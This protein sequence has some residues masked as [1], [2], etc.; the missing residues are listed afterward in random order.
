[1]SKARSNGIAIL[2]KGLKKLKTAPLLLEAMLQ[3]IHCWTDDTKYELVG[4][5]HPL[6]FDYQ[7]SQLLEHQSS[8]GWEFLLKGYL[9]KECRFIQGLYYKYMKVNQGKFHKDRWMLQVLML[10][11]QYRH[12]LWMLRNAAI[13]GG[14]DKLQGQVFCHRLLSEVQDLYKRDRTLLSLQHKGLFKLPLCYREKQGNQQLLLWIK[15]AYIVFDKLEDSRSKHQQ[16]QITDWLTNWTE[17][18]TSMA[19]VYQNKEMNMQQQQQCI[20]NF[21]KLR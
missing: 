13:H 7:H 5:S 16:T 11:Y 8:I 12:D 17:D 6:L 15:H 20:T 4:E 21:I 9:A 3:G 2:T 14:S 10:L 18:L 1:M 19:P